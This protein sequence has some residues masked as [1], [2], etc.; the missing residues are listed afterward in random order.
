MYS[1]DI[2]NSYKCDAY[3]YLGVTEGIVGNMVP[4]DRRH[5]T[6]Y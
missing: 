4:L 3:G 1:K 6:S 2:I 5:A